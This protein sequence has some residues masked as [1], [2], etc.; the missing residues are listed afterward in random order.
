MTTQYV[1]GLAFV[2]G[3]GWTLGGA[4]GSLLVGMVIGVG[5]GIREAWHDMRAKETNG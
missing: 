2:A 4:L 5:R 3:L 1:L